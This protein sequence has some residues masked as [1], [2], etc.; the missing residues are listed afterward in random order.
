MAA[1]R[2]LVVVG[3]VNAR[4]SRADDEELTTSVE[5]QVGT[6]LGVLQLPH[7]RFC[8]CASAATVVF[9]LERSSGHFIG[10]KFEF[11]KS[12]SYVGGRNVSVHFACGESD[13]PHR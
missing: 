5:L 9:T 1:E 10:G 11:F 13:R 12:F 4:R 6:A 8:S 2:K 3:A 7:D